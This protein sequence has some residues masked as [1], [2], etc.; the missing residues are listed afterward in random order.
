MS[1]RVLCF[2]EVLLRLSAPDHE[3]LLQSGRLD[4][5]FGGAEVNVA[6][7]LAQLG[8]KARLLTAAPDNALGVAALREVRRYGVEI[9]HVLCT[10]G[11]LGLY[12]LTPGAVLRP[13]E[14][15]Y[16]RADSGFAQAAPE[17]FNFEQAL[18]ECAWVHVSGITPAVGPKA[19][20]AVLTLVSAAKAR[21]VK[22]SFDG[23]YR[24]KMWAAWQGDGPAVLREILA[25]ADLLFGDER[26][27][28][29]VLGATFEGDLPTRRDA[30][31]AAAF[32]AFPNLERVCAT[33]RIQHGVG[34]HELSATLHRRDGQVW[35]A[36]A[37]N[38]SGI[39]DRIGAGDAF[40]AGVLHGV[41]SDWPDARALRFG[42]AAAGFKHSVPGDF[43]L[44]SEAMILE[45]LADEDLSVRR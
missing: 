15:L 34:V 26:D 7:S 21:G 32:D 22:V 40:A 35:R 36:P 1:A 11:R 39:V 9:D 42:L 5:R 41:L 23:N 38:L 12:F 13:S 6:V 8:H 28:A 10:Q 14:V 27:V 45:A 31:A 43:N 20:F 30:A 24:A 25:S 3:V 17:D 44:A 4:A 18:E 29:L 19:S 33:A 37:L 16:D 2:G